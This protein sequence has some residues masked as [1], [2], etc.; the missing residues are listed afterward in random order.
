MMGIAVRR[1]GRDEFHPWLSV[2]RQDI[3]SVWVWSLGL[4]RRDIHIQVA[5][6]TAVTF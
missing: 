6:C 3:E 1:R 4:G 5:L 2:C